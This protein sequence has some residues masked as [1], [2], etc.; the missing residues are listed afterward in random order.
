MRKH[1]PLLIVAS[2]IAGAI[3]ATPIAVLA[4][5]QFVDVPT[6]N[7]FHDDIAWIADKGVTLGCSATEYCPN[8][9]VTR[10]QM[11]AF[12]HRLGVNQV[13]DAAELEGLTA[14]EVVSQCPAGTTLF[15][16]SCIENTARPAA[17]WLV[18]AQ[19]CAAERRRLPAPGELLG[20]RDL[21]GIT[22][23][24]EWTDDVADITNGLQI[25]IATDVGTGTIEDPLSPLQYRCVAGLG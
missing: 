25:Y 24:A 22:L 21:P 11:A 16:S 14:T 3:L 6:S 20:F 9:F 2:A 15:V 4:S 19:V 13:V 8:D 23:G 12:L 5:H 7:I 10:E 17:P 1:L 18:A